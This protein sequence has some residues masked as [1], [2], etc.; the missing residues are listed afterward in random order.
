MNAAGAGERRATRLRERLA[1]AQLDALLVTTLVDARYLTGFT[2]SSAVVVAREDGGVL[3]TDFRYTEQSAAQVQPPYEPRIV[4]GEPIEKLSEVLSSGGRLGFDERAVTVS[5][6]RKLGEVVGPDWELVPVGNPVAKLREIKEADEI[7]ALRTA[8]QIADAALSEVLE[9]GLVGRSE[10]EIATALEFAMRRRGAIAGSFP[11][12]V[13]SGERGSRPHAEVTDEPIAADVFVTFDWG[14]LSDGY[15]SDCTRTVATG[16]GVGAVEREIYELTLRGQLAGLDFLAP[17]R[18]GREVDAAARAVIDA[19]GYGENFG[20]GLGHGVG[21]E[22]HEP[23]RLAKLGGD[24]PLVAGN[25]VTV[26][27]GIYIPGVGGVR[28]EDLV[29]IGES[30]NEVLTSLPKELIFVA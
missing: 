17:G 19:G 5:E 28:I 20:H 11:A 10:R 12:I 21:L 4:T 24:V 15:C 8:A 22:I 25:V 14:A 27:P 23:P 1:E 13:A 7:D 29:V 9:A 6:H 26:E 3:L 16:E 2:G 18:S 30:A